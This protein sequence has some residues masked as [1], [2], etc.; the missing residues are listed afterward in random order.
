MPFLIL[1]ES[2]NGFTP[3]D[4]GEQVTCGNNYANWI[5]GLHMNFCT[6]RRMQSILK[7]GDFFPLLIFPKLHSQI[8]CSTCTPKHSYLSHFVL[9]CHCSSSCVSYTSKMKE[10]E[11]WYDKN[12]IV[13]PNCAFCCLAIL[14]SLIHILIREVVAENQGFFINTMYFK[15]CFCPCIHTYRDCSSQPL[16]P[17]DTPQL[18]CNV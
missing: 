2:E 11:D 1:Q 18:S 17:R 9:G 4:L 10:I 13:L 6:G 7:R 3:A 15:R 14:C 16:F 5:I 12:N 8:L